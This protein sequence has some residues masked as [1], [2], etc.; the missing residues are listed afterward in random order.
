MVWWC[1]FAWV[2][3]SCVSFCAVLES[4]LDFKKKCSQFVKPKLL[5]QSPTTKSFPLFPTVLCFLF[6]ALIHFLTHQHQSYTGSTL[7]S[8]ISNAGFLNNCYLNK[9]NI[10]VLKIVMIFRKSYI[11]FERFHVLKIVIWVTFIYLH[12]PHSCSS[13]LWGGEQM[14]TRVTQ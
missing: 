11:I 7:C 14:W 8:Y 10:C 4:W 6:S 2:K 12:F 13:I 3:G 1:L 5:F 9:N